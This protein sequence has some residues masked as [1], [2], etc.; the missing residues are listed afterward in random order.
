M[1]WLAQHD[2]VLDLREDSDFGYTYAYI[3]T[4]V[5]HEER[6]LVYQGILSHFALTSTGQFSY[7]VL[8]EAERSYLRMGEQEAAVDKESHLIGSSSQ[9]PSDRER[10]LSYLV[11]DGADIEKLTQV[12]G[13]TYNDSWWNQFTSLSVL[14]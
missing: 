7:L 11:L 1:R 2:W 14:F 8:S 10:L 3:L 13:R 5:S 4:R 12:N 6:R 9:N